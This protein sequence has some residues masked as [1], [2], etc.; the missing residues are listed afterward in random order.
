MIKKIIIVKPYGYH[1]GG[2]VLEAL[3]MYLRKEGIDARIF[4]IFNRHSDHTK[5][6]SIWQNLFWGLLNEFGFKFCHVLF[7][8]RLFIRIRERYTFYSKVVPDIKRQYLPFFSKSSTVVLYPDVVFDNF[9]NGINVV[10]WL[11]FYNRYTNLSLSY[12]SHDL[13]VCFR[14]IFNDWV[15]NPNCLQVTINYFDRHKYHQYNFGS[16]EGKCY[17]IRKG[18]GRSDLPSVYDGPVIDNMDEVEKVRIFNRV[19]YCYFYD[20]QTFY[21]LIAAVCGCIPI[22]VME[23]QKSKSDYLSDE[24]LLNS[25]GVAYGDSPDEIEYAIQ[26]RELLLKKMDYDAKN[27]VEARKLISYIEERFG[28]I[29]KKQY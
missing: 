16:R 23:P 27:R 22:V 6:F 24:E 29:S 21:T 12:G 14:K 19:K 2:L 15:L 20:T 4:Y 7:L 5:D 17:L 26:T 18:S 1:G 10:R 9:L 8:D 11:L 3:G 25:V 13:V 28:S